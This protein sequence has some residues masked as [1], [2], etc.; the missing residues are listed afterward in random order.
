MH[1]RASFY[2]STLSKSYDSETGKEK[3]GSQKENWIDD[4]H[5]CRLWKCMVWLPG[6]VIHMEQ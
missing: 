6:N 5:L 3:E 1:C 4:T 2:F